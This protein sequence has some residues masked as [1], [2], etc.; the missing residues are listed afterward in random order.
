MMHIDYRT[1]LARQ[2]NAD[3]RNPVQDDVEG[4]AYAH[5]LRIST[6][7]HFYNKGKRLHNA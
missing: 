5:A 6:F 3:P 4:Y 1:H 7:T 2:Y